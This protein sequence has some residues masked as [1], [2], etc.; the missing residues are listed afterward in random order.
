MGDALTRRFAERLWRHRLILDPFDRRSGDEFV[1]VLERGDR[2]SIDVVLERVLEDLG[3]S[4]RSY[5]VQLSEVDY[6]SP[7]AMVAGASRL[8]DHGNRGR[9]A[10]RQ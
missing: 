8:S 6:P 1:L 10:T 9:H 4:A 7:T 5:S 2:R 3:L